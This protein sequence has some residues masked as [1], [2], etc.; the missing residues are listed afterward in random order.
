MDW[1]CKNG[2]SFVMVHCK[3]TY[4]AIKGH[5]QEITRAIIVYDTRV[6]VHECSKAKDIGY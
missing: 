1:H 3:K 4:I 5:E 2:V 6:F